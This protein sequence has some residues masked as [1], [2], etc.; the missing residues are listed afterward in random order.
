MDVSVASV[1]TYDSSLEFT[2]DNINSRDFIPTAYCCHLDTLGVSLFCFLTLRD[3]PNTKGD[4]WLFMLA[5]HLT[6]R[7]TRVPYTQSNSPCK[8]A[9]LNKKERDFL[10]NRKPLATPLQIYR[11]PINQLIDTNIFNLEYLEDGRQENRPMADIFISVSHFT[12]L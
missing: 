12:T 7:H 9:Y 5:P 8:L 4:F 11:I 1:E 6:K 3:T 10:A 2:D